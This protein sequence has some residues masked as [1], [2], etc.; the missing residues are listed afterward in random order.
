[1]EDTGGGASP[2]RAT[3]APAAAPVAPPLMARAFSAPEQSDTGAPVPRTFDPLDR[4]AGE[5]DRA[6]AEED[7]PRPR[8][9]RSQS[10]LSLRTLRATQLHA[11]VLA[12]RGGATSGAMAL[13][14]LGLGV[15][16]AAAAASKTATTR[17]PLLEKMASVFSRSSS[18]RSSSNPSLLD[19]VAEGVCKETGA[20]SGLDSPRPASESNFWGGGVRHDEPT[21]AASNSEADAADGLV[22]RPAAESSSFL[23]IDLD[24]VFGNT[25]DYG[26]SNPVVAGQSGPSGHRNLELLDLARAGK[27]ALLVNDR[28]AWVT[29]LACIRGYDATALSSVSHFWQERL[30]RPSLARPL[31][32]Y[33]FRNEFPD[34]DR[35]EAYGAVTTDQRRLWREV[36]NLFHFVT[37]AMRGAEQNVHVVP[38]TTSA[39]RSKRKPMRSLFIKEHNDR[40]ERRR[41]AVMEERRV[42][43]RTRVKAKRLCQRRCIV[44]PVLCVGSCGCLAL[45]VP[46]LALTN[47]LLMIQASVVEDAPQGSAAKEWS[48]GGYGAALWIWPAALIGLCWCMAF[49]CFT[50]HSIMS[51]CQPKR[52]DDPTIHTYV[53]LCN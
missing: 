34:A 6:A 7:H 19:T 46:L 11:R 26:T 22:S 13:R 20:E 3:S 21:S 29:M 33:Y 45:P 38:T 2:L 47:V 9:Q 25:P 27:L 30:A 24:A 4:M 39:D 51:F 53:W 40:N 8:A 50:F 52:N 42:K 5:E 44:H 14:D 28:T 32:A 31:W 16:R 36:P 1:M 37:V 41:E 49:T 35:S 23:P 48:A 43:V 17:P 18:S 15:P 12:A 10:M